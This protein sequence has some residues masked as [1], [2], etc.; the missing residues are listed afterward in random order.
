M[1][2]RGQWLSN[3]GWIDLERIH[4]NNFPDVSLAK[5]IEELGL[6]FIWIDHIHSKLVTTLLLIHEYS[7]T[8]I[9]MKSFTTLINGKIVFFLKSFQPMVVDIRC[10]E[11]KEETISKSADLE[12]VRSSANYG[13]T[14]TTNNKKRHHQVVHYSRLELSLSATRKEATIRLFF[15]S[16]CHKVSFFQLLALWEGYTDTFATANGREL[17]GGC[18]CHIKWEQKYVTQTWYCRI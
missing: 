14:A 11:K 17:S 12:N 4:T 16:S 5:R 13:P 2:S 10:F 8:E 1:A 6:G 7:F 18:C 15:F 3:S 9:C